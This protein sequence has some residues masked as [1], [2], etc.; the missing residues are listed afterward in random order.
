MRR[1]GR[2]MTDFM[3]RDFATHQKVA[4]KL[5]GYHL[6]EC[7]LVRTR[8]DPAPFSQSGPALRAGLPRDGGLLSTAE[9]PRW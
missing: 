4:H 3:L 5:P 6:A 7:Q 2:R 8:E 1:V 9:A